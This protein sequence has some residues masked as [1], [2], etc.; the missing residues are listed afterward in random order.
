M[1][2]YI[3]VHQR[4][5]RDHEIKAI[6]DL[7]MHMCQEQAGSVGQSTFS[8]QKQF[9]LRSRR[10]EPAGDWLFRVGEQK[11]GPSNS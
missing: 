5:A 4:T 7:K 6:P 2:R 3:F 11:V 9:Y 8:M 10:T 1:V